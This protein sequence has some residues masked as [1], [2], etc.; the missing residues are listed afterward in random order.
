MLSVL[1]SVILTRC[2]QRADL[3]N[4]TH[5]SEAELQTLVSEQVGEMQMLVGGAGYNYFKT[6]AT[7]SLSTFAVPT[8]HLSTIGVGFG[9]DTAGRRRPLVELMEQDRDGFLGTTGEAQFYILNAQTIELYPVPSAGT[10]KHVYIPQPTDISAV[11]T[12]TSVDLVSPDGLAFVIE[13]VAVKAL[14]KS[15]TDVQG[16]MIARDEAKERLV[17]WALHRSFHTAK[18]L[19]MPR[20][21]EDYDDGHGFR[22]ES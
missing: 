18:R 22:W 17:E 8:D 13:G 10:Y 7:I 4:D 12:T 19:T 9:Y 15:E 21:S 6:E 11:A 2:R 1:V 20:F 5:V 16:F 14:R 3:E